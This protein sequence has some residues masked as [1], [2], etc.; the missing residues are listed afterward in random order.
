VRDA[1]RKGKRDI[2]RRYDAEKK[3]EEDVHLLSGKE[4]DRRE[5]R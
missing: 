1:E 5:G 4:R 2:E 3:N